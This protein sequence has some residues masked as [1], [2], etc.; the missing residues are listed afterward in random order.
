MVLISRK[1]E[2][3]VCTS[4]IEEPQNSGNL[5]HKFA[6]SLGTKDNGRK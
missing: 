5:F 2:F 4:R 1:K 3:V 6:G